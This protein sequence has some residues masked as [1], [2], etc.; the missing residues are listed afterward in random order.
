MLRVSYTK[1]K[2][3]IIRRVPVWLWILIDF[4]TKLD[5]IVELKNTGALVDPRLLQDSNVTVQCLLS[6]FLL[7]ILFLLI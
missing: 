7:F 3:A 2:H 5:W 4:I 1:V 6:Y